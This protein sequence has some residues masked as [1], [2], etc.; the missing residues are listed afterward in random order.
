[1]GYLE[2]NERL[3]FFGDAVLQL[4]VTDYIFRTYQQMPEGMLAKLR[5]TVVNSESL[6][7]V[8]RSIGLGEVL[9]LGKGEEAT[10]G[11]NKSSILAD[12]LE[13]LVGAIYLEHERDKDDGGDEGD[14]T[15]GRNGFVK[16]TEFILQHL[17]DKIKLAA[18]NPGSDDYKTRLQELATQ[19]G[20]GLPV[21]QISYNGP[22]HARCFTA[23][24][25]I[26]GVFLAKAEGRSKKQAEQNAAEQ[27]CVMML[28]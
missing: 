8:S 6:A 4:A 14:S 13:A 17:E 16:S 18:S 1:M 3:E 12:A 2:S 7:E 15:G 25:Y 20:K 21:Y 24:V 19:Q 26:A 9:F 27:A 22:D 11:R 28:R 5:A 23:E 10:G